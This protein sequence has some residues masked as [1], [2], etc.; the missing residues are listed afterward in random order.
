MDHF[1]T[2]I[3][4]LIGGVLIG[5]SAT[6]LMLFNGRVAGISGIANRLLLLKVGDTG[7][8]LAF[9]FGLLFTGGLLGWSHPELF[10]SPTLGSFLKILVGALLVGFGTTLANG[11]TS[12]H[13]I[14]GL[15]RLSTRSLAAVISFMLAG[16]ITVFL[17]R[18]LLGGL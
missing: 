9:V 12:G 4:P 14:C 7:W 5:L 3:R 15:S 17:M 16:V 1:E 11:C 2:I 10:G 6:G 18:T 8:R 13:G